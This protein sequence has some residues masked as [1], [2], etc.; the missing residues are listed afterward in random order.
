M[1]SYLVAG[2]P[3]SAA[4]LTTAVRE[5]GGKQLHPS[6]CI[7]PWPGTA[8]ALCSKLRTSVPGHVAVCCIDSNDFDYQ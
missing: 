6:C 1:N 2:E 3:S 5:I 7:A 8:D 4:A